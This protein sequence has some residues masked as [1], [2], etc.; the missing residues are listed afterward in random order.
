MTVLRLLYRMWNRYG[1]DAT[2]IRGVN[3]DGVLQFQANC[4]DTIQAQREKLLCAKMLLHGQH[5]AQHLESNRLDATGIGSWELNDAGK[6]VR[7][8]AA[9]TSNY[10]LS[11]CVET[12]QSNSENNGICL[13]ESAEVMRSTN[14]TLSEP[15]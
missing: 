8:D 6:R 12:L 1:A 14:V 11:N 3:K 13:R 2:N 9:R 5:I 7:P 15:P 4:I 10:V